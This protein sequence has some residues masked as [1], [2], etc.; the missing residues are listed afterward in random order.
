MTTR[1]TKTFDDAKASKTPVLVA[2]L[3]VGDPSVEDSVKVALACVA[4]GADILEL[5]VPFSDPT[6]DGPAIARASQRAIAAGGGLEA[7]LKAAAE[8]RAQ[9]SVPIVL[10]G[11]YNP[12]LVRGEDVTIDDAA[13]AGV[14]ALLIVDLPLDEGTT[15]RARAASYSIPI[16]PLV[17]PAT[18][19][20]RLEQIRAQG[21]QKSGFVYYVSV[22]GV[23]GVANADLDR[24]GAAAARTR[25]VV[26][27]PVVIGFGIDNATKAKA[28]ATGADGI[29]IGTAIVV[30]VENA[31]T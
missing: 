13:K 15:L 4:A 2:Y 22:T 16:V 3:C 7:T 11:Y 9:C 20:A 27:M 21:Q 14:D 1:L 10:F 29:V 17:T 5:G 6:A 8:I 23:T 30:R 18:T 19:P 24:A 26:R 28:A 25:D 31:E 12:I